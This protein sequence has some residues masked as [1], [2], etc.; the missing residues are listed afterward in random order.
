MILIGEKINGTRKKVAQAVADRDAGFILALAKAQ[1]EAGS[2]Y[3]DVNAGTTPEREPDDLV[4][5]V[6][7]I[8]AGVDTPLCLDS[9]NPEALKA[10]VSVVK[11]TPLINSISAEKE[12]LEGILPVA[13]QYG[14]PVIALSLGERTVPETSQERLENVRF[15]MDAARSRGLT[16]DMIFVDPLALTISTNTNNAVTAFETMRLVKSEFPQAHLVV[17]LSNISYGLPARP[18]I[19]RTFLVLAM[20]A[21]LDAAILDPLD[22]ELTSAVLAAELVLGN[23]NYCMNFIRASR[24]GL[25][26][27][28]AIVPPPTPPP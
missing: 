26:N 27:P 8:Q 14:C 9:A 20:Q 5:L 7:T 24:K 3:L 19:N 10:A 12:R 28:P 23:D 6:E 16:E 2:A 15:V 21:G 11:K 1:A 18:L 25:L 4:W 22:R 13:A 17:G